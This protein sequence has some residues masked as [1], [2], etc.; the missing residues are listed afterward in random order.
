MMGISSQK[1]TAMPPA[2]I[3]EPAHTREFLKLA[4]SGDSAAE[5]ALYRRFTLVLSEEVRKHKVMRFL[6]RFVPED[7]VVSEIWLRCYS[8]GAIHRFN[9]RGEGSFRKFLCKIL[10]RTLCDLARRHGAG[11]RKTALMLRTF[12]EQGGGD[13]SSV[14][15]HEL[16]PSREPSPTSSARVSEMRAICEKTLDSREWAVWKMAESDGLDSSE[17]GKRVGLS[18]STVRG[19][20]SGAQRKLVLALKQTVSAEDRP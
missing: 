3:P 11:K 14:P 18:P 8:S 19:I 9:D 17:I 15:P 16:P 10:N 1:G 5:K 6:K 2:S 13:D 4:L 20:I 12:A 7:D